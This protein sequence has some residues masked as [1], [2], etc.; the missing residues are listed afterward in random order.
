MKKG[1]EYKGKNN[2]IHLFSEHIK[3]IKEN[4]QK[5]RGYPLDSRR[6]NQLTI[7]EKINFKGAYP[8]A[9]YYDF[10]KGTCIIN[11]HN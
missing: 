9:R 11:Y 5:Y 6:H 1:N 2:V 4:S 7:H 10:N 3:L 8:F